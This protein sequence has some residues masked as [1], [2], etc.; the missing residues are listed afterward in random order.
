M[1][2]TKS[3]IAATKKD[4]STTKVDVAGPRTILE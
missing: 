2:E 3:S 4:L 1:R